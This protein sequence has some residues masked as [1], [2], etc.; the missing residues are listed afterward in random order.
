MSNEG[1]S[2]GSDKQVILITGCE[3]AVGAATARHFLEEE[4][5][6]YATTA[7][8]S[9]IEALAEEGANTME[10][11]PTDPE[12]AAQVVEAIADE[13]DQ[14]NCVVMVPT[15]SQRG[16]IEDVPTRRVQEQFD[17]SVL[18]FH[19][20]LRAALPHMRSA[21]D[22]TIIAISSVLGR[23]SVPGMGIPA[24]SAFALEGFSD[25]LRMELQPHE[26]DVSVIQPGPINGD[27]DA[28]ADFTGLE[29]T[30]GYEAL[31]EVYQEAGAFGGLGTIE[32]EAVA[33]AVHQAASCAE[34]APRYPVGQVASIA[35]WARFLPTSI[36]DAVFGML[37][38]LA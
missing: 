16:A 13:V 18:G 6:V 37:R 10:L 32:P 34:P 14:L 7:D 19:R 20:L 28:D 27:G 8:A 5:T 25:A 1:P 15:V 30:G 22:G 38:R 24:A 31:Y 35:L 21:S 36:R 12:D 26:V 2:N 11:D 9:S 33:E 3:T 29:R 23:V 17:E 4:W